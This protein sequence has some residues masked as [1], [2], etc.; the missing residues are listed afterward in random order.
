MDN[1]I[2]GQ[3]N[4]NLERIANA[5]DRIAV[6]MD[7]KN[8]L[9]SESLTEQKTGVDLH[10]RQIALIEAQPFVYEEPLPKENF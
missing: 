6:L 1:T 3:M 7:R 9:L 2:A 5:L 8:D 4:N 10:R